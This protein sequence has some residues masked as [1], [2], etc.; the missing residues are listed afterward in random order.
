MSCSIHL[1]RGYWGLE[2]AP[3]P[4]FQGTRNIFCNI[5]PTMVHIQSSLVSHFWNQLVG[6]HFTTE[7]CH[8]GII[9]FPALNGTTTVQLSAWGRQSIFPYLSFL[10]T[11]WIVL[12]QNLPLRPA[13]PQTW[14]NMIMHSFS[15]Q[16]FPN[17]PNAL[18]S[19]KIL[20]K[21][22][23]SFYG[24]WCLKFRWLNKWLGKHM[25]EKYTGIFL[26]GKKTMCR[27]RCPKL[28]KL[29][30]RLLWE[31]SLHASCLLLFN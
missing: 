19:T 17:E 20:I 13:D 4:K 3:Q 7:C 8:F 22:W 11:I 6:W 28:C 21:L 30:N 29:W 16:H 23:K 25:E 2:T 1:C 27:L 26:L 12:I 14:I 10:Q 9:S 15:C 31:V 24:M 5:L 18:L